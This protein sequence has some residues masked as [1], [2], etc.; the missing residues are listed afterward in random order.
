MK[1]YLKVNWKTHFKEGYFI[2]VGESYDDCKKYAEEYAEYETV[3][4]TS[5]HESN[6]DEY[7]EFLEKGRSKWKS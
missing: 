3:N 2:Q 6:E 4:I 5:F 7:E 1:K